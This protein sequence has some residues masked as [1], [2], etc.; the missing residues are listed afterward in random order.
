M[1]GYRNVD[2]L[3][4]KNHVSA[5]RRQ[6][7]AELSS[8][9]RK[10]KGRI[11]SAAVGS[12]S[13]TSVVES[14]YPGRCRVFAHEKY[15]IVTTN[16]VMQPHEVHPNTQWSRQPQ[17]S[18]YTKMEIHDYVDWTIKPE[19]WRNPAIALDENA[20]P[21]EQGNEGVKQH[22]NEPDKQDTEAPEE[23][24]PNNDSI[25]LYSCSQCEEDLWDNLAGDRSLQLRKPEDATYEGMPNARVWRTY[26]DVNRIHGANMGDKS[27]EKGRRVTCLCLFLAVV[28]TF[29]AQTYQ[30]LQAEYAPR[31][32]S[33]PFDLALVQRAITDGSLINTIRPFFPQS[34]YR[35]R[36][37]HHGRLVNGLWFTSLFLSLTTAL[38]TVLTKQWLHHYVVLPRDHSFT[39]RF[40]YAGFQ[41]WH[42][43]VIIGLLPVLMPLDSKPDISRRID[44]FLHP[45][46]GALYGSF[47]QEPSLSMAYM[48]A[49]SLP[50]LFPRCPYLSWNRKDHFLRAWRRRQL[51]D[52][53]HSCANEENEV[54]DNDGVRVRAADDHEL[55]G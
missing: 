25:Q 2:F 48:V 10:R 37:C 6:V 15:N 23:K 11:A 22:R 49:T 45:L 18:K 52:A 7:S 19:F 12:R 39:R 8:R 51:S 55:G 36:A 4:T 43:L 54:V 3:N 21:E 27:Q 42:V 13:W 40:R 38:V 14:G 31:S 33:L 28:T 32:E 1:A 29:V 20:E 47:V 30:H 35:L 5:E 16:T 24:S 26:E 53:I 17:Y 46:R 44:G 9:H 34:Q 41:K 50:I